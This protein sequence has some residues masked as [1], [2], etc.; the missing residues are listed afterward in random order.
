MPHINL[1]YPFINHWDPGFEEAATRFKTALQY[2]KPFKVTFNLDSFGYFKHGK[3]ATV[4]LKPIIAGEANAE[5]R[6]HIVLVFAFFKINY[7]QSCSFLIAVGL[8]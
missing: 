1:L 5:V 7:L 2:V 6:G 3:N 8:K 4:W